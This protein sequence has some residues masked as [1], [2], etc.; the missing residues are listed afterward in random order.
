MSAT[1]KKI[2][3]MEGSW[4]SVADGAFVESATDMKW[5][6]RGRLALQGAPC[7]PEM[8]ETRA[9]P[10][11]E[12]EQGGVGEGSAAAVS[13][14]GRS[15]AEQAGGARESAGMRCVNG[16]GRGLGRPGPQVAPKTR[17]RGGRGGPDGAEQGGPQPRARW[18]GSSSGLCRRQQR[19]GA[20]RGH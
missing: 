2:L 20:L 11:S 8:G 15:L 18:P 16:S 5:G 10:A 6:T 4:G 19:C 14:R 7:C 1:L 3:L 13:V 17:R 9:F 12:G